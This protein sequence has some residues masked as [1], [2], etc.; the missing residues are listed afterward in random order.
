MFCFLLSDGWD[1]SSYPVLLLHC[2]FIYGHQIICFSS[3][4]FIWNRINLKELCLYGRERKAERD[5]THR[6]EGDVKVEAE[7]RGRLVIKKKRDS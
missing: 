6:E 4:F 3:Q 5:L 1:H 2:S 7:I